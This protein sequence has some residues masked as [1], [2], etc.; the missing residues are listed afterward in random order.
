MIISGVIFFKLFFNSTI[1]LK[2]ESCNEKIII[3]PEDF[4]MKYGGNCI[5][6]GI[7]AGRS[8]GSFFF[9]NI[10]NNANETGV[11]ISNV[12]ITKE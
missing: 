5:V 8:F 1:L 3:K 2:G 11:Y 10:T 4:K 6:C 7:P 12:K 9:N